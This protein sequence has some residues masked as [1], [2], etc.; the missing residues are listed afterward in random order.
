MPGMAA[1]PHLVFFPFPSQGHVT[2]AFQLA[3]LLHHCHGFDVTF[4]HTEHNRR[5][6]LRAR[7]PGAQAGAPGFRFAAVPDG[8]PPSDEDASRDDAA[9]LLLSLP[10]VVP[11][12]KD[13]VLSELHAASCRRLLLVSDIDPILRAAQ[14]IG[15]PCV[16]FWITSASSF[17]AMQQVQH[18]VAKGLVPLKGTVNGYDEKLFY[19]KG[20]VW[21]QTLD[22]IPPFKII[23]CLTFL[24]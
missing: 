12:F 19:Q 10:T 5:R 17:M 1:K 13:L 20:A 6:L 24:F 21:I 15:L 22:L 18:L 2:P 11:Q 4:V 9:A 3:R 8:L 7:G 16:T 14:E 23:G